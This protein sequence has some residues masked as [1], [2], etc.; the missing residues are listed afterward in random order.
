MIKTKVLYLIYSLVFP[1]A[2]FAQNCQEEIDKANQ[3]YEDGIYREAEVITKQILDSCELNKTQRNEMLKLMASIYYEMDELELAEEYIAD[4]VKKNPNYIPSN[5]K[6]AHQ[7]KLAFNKIKS[8]PS[9]SV[10]LRIGGSLAMPSALKIYPNSEFG[11][12]TKDYTAKPALTAALDLSWNISNLIALNLGPGYRSYSLQHE[13]AMFD[14][15]LSFNYE[16]TSN[17]VFLPV[18]IMGTI[19]LNDK[20]YISLG[21]GGELLYYIDGAY[22]YSYSGPGLLTDEL[23]Y[24][25]DIKNEDGTIETVERNQ[26]RY[27]AV[28][29]LR[30]SYRHEKLTFFFDARYTQEFSE[31]TDKEHKY[32]NPD[33]Y[34]LN[35]YA[36]ADLQISSIDFSIGVLYNF[37]YRVK[38]KY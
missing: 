7:F 33:L 6:D 37:A 5:K 21:V 12:Y 16:E 34:L 19:P 36:L 30:F 8:W 9:F 29:A 20:L 3:L 13:V 32:Y 18:L 14:N 31:Y 2:V 4:F 35:S 38:S 28:A 27:G 24:F 10:G 15:Q 26:L 22:K 11:D 1:L 17:S 25:Q 23:S